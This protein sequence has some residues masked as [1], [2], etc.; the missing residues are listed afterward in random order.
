MYNHDL[1]EYYRQH[2]YQVMPEEE[3][4]PTSQTGDLSLEEINYYLRKGFDEAEKNKNS[5]KSFKVAQGYGENVMRDFSTPFLTPEDILMPKYPYPAT[6]A[7]LS[8]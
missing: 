4:V 8:G 5:A 7:I 3:N 2:N 6:L 1:K